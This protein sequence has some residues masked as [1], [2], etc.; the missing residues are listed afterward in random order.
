MKHFYRLILLVFT[1]ASGSLFAQGDATSSDGNPGF[2]P[3]QIMVQIPD[4]NMATGLVRELSSI[5]GIQTDVKV[6]KTLSKPMSIYLLTFNPDAIDEHTMLDAAKRHP[7]VS[8]AQLNH[9]VTLRETV[10]NDP[11]FD[12]QWHHVNDGSGS[13]TADADIDSDEAWD[14]TTG[15]TTATGDEIVICV[16]E[17]GNLEHPDLIGNAWVNTQEIPDNGIDDDG[18][19]YIDDVDGWNVSSN[20]DEGVFQGGHGTQVMGMIGAKGDNNLGVVGANWNV[21]IMSVAGES[22]QSEAS[23]VEAYTYPLVMRQL[24]TSSGGTQ[25]AFVVATNA[26][27]GLDNADP[28]NS[29]IWCAVYETLGENGILNCGATTNN[30]VN[31]DVNGDVPTACPSPYMVSVTATNNQDVRTFSGYGVV[32]VDVGAPGDNI[33]T[34]SGSD[35]YGSTSG[36]SFASPLTAGVIGLLYSTP[37]GSLAQIA[38]ANPQLGADMVL[39]ALYEGVDVIPNLIGEVATGGRINA[40]NSIVYL[41]DNCDES[42]C[43]APFSLNVSQEENTTN[44]TLNWGGIDPVSYDLRYRVVGALDWIEVNGIVEESYLAA[45]LAYCSQYEFQVRANC[46]E[47]SSDY[48]NS[49]VWETDGCC[50]NPT[51]SVSD[52]TVSEA[53]VTWNSVLA[54]DNFTVRYRE[55]G[56]AEWVVVSNVVD[57]QLQLDNLEGCTPYEVQI[58]TVCAD[59]DDPFSGSIE[60]NT[61]GCA[62]CEEGDYCASGGDDNSYEWIE[63]VEF[64]SF[65]N[66]SGAGVTGYSDFSGGDSHLM[67]IGEEQT[68]TLTMGYDSDPYNEHFRIWIDYNQDGEFTPDELVFSQEEQGV[69][70]PVSGSFIVSETAVPGATRMRVVMKYVAGGF[71]GFDPPAEACETFGYGETEDYCVYIDEVSGLNPSEFGGQMSAYPNPVVSTLTLDLG[72]A[73]GAVGATEYQITDATGRTVATGGFNAAQATLDMSQ[74]DSGVYVVSVYQDGTQIARQQVVKV[75]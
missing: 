9:Y 35:G 18:N 44:Y 40:Y 55:I 36:T 39:E 75:N 1:V 8:L 65:S 21:K 53:L 73:D 43:F 7:A 74:Y 69:T 24:Y 66:T 29:P 19:G 6:A 49:F 34:T 48:T 71:F 37:C 17:G 58:M 50:E 68:F 52:V 45:D 15:G 33:F 25:G 60:F 30:N 42:G 14:I 67:V 12:S 23:V 54:A 26:S 56:T 64:S 59:D 2:V 31:I 72:S 13:A 11:Q 46:D 5:N 28:D 20:N 38:M 10:P 61:G 41:L 47:E 57:V 63:S 32:N 22:A 4:A 70:S 51:L 62:T 3:G 16:I 27:W